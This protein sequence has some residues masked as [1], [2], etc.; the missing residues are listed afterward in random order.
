MMT[1]T[2][3]YCWTE[4]E[5]YDD[6]EGCQLKDEKLLKSIECDCCE[7]QLDVELE[8]E[9]VGATCLT[10]NNT[11]SEEEAYIQHCDHLI[12]LHRDREMG[13]E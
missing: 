11:L 9:V 8:V 5:I 1:I 10:K 4:V 6:L 13:F 2:C 12:D 7:K 3:P